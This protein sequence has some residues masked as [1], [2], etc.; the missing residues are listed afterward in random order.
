VIRNIN[1]RV[2]GVKSFSADTNIISIFLYEITRII[3]GLSVGKNRHFFLLP[4]RKVV[5]F[6]VFF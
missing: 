2:N 5:N 1:V 6:G 3:E 4:K